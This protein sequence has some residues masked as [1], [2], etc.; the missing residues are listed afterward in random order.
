MSTLLET[1]AGKLII[2]NDYWL[3]NTFCRVS[4]PLLC[5]CGAVCSNSKVVFLLEAVILESLVTE[6]NPGG[7]GGVFTCGFLDWLGWFHF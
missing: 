3:V 6:E 5:L 2:R 7:L 4:N 1:G